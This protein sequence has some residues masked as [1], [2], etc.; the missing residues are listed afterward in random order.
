MVL[1]GGDQQGKWFGEKEGID[2]VKRQFAV[3]N[4]AQQLRVCPS[5]GTKWFHRQRVA[6][7]WHR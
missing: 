7:L 3:L 6:T 5:A 4:C 2:I 1:A